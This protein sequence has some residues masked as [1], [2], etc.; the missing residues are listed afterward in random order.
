[1]PY[2]GD[3]QNGPATGQTRPGSLLLHFLCPPRPSSCPN[4]GRAPE[5]DSQGTALGK[6]GRPQHAAGGSGPCLLSCSPR[7][8]LPS[9]CLL[10]FPAAACCGGLAAPRTQVLE[11]QTLPDPEKRLDNN[12]STP[13]LRSQNQL[14][15]CPPWKLM[16]EQP[17]PAFAKDP[18]C[19]RLPSQPEYPRVAAPPTLAETLGAN[20]LPSPSTSRQ[21][22]MEPAGSAPRFPTLTRLGSGLQ[23]P[24]SQN[25]CPV[26]PLE[27]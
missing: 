7:S 9:V 3:R 10:C 26:H 19:A 27:L 8:F 5:E 1:M 13:G 11:P 24:R 25:T 14:L 12:S 18:L 6:V 21:T 20:T 23:E 15:D 4:T 17:K 2:R 16:E 22:G